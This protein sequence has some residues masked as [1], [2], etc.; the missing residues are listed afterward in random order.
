MATWAE[1]WATSDGYQK[2][3]AAKAKQDS[4]FWERHHK[5]MAELDEQDRITRMMLGDI[6]GSDPGRSVPGLVWVVVG[7]VVL[8]VIAAIF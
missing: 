2:A 8:A 7:V 1:Q 4:E 5:V 3:M 6:G